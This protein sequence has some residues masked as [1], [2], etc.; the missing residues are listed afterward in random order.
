MIWAIVV[1]IAYLPVIYTL[2]KRISKLED[3]VR[4]LENK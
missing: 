4:E 3:K 1:I 2:N